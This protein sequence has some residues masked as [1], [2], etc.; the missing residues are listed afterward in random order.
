MKRLLFILFA[1]LCFS[2]AHANTYPYL[3]FTKTDGSQVSVSVE[4]LTITIADGKL[5]ASNGRE[6]Q[7]LKLSSLASMSFTSSS[8]TAINSIT[9]DGYV[10]SSDSAPVQAFTTAGTAIGTYRNLTAF[11]SQ[12]PRGVYIIKSNGRTQKIMVR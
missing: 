4:S 2:I 5:I 6:E 10:S 8:A 1:T 12:A 7:E 3:T 11:L 9:A